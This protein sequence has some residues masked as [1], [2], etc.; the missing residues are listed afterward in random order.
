VELLA[1]VFAALASE[2]ADLLGAL[3]TGGDAP[4]A[5]ATADRDEQEQAQGRKKKTKVISHPW[6]IPDA[7]GSV[8]PASRACLC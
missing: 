2:A 1:L 3:L 4:A 7:G 6:K 5:A 8:N